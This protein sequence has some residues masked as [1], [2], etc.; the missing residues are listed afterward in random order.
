MQINDEEDALNVIGRNLANLQVEIVSNNHR[1]IA[2]EPID[3]GGD[4]LGPGPYELLLSALGAC[5]VMTVQLYA[6]RKGWDV[7]KV[8]VAMDTYKVYARDCDDCVS[9]KDAK[10]DIIELNLHLEGDLTP[11]Q[12][13]RLT[14]IA[15][16]CPVHR[17][18]TN[19]I[20]IRVQ[21]V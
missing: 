4:D 19:E 8:E 10:V 7:R 21:P 3:D 16:K 1:W 17:T 11:E 6:R 13:A 15:H 14:E 18:L 12:M 9:D 5:T 20:K 2:D